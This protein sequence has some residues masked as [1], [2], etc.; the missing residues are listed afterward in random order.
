MSLKKFGIAARVRRAQ[1]PPLP[2]TTEGKKEVKSLLFLS[3]FGGG[4][5]HTHSTAETTKK[6]F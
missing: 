3:V 5:A 1:Q 2:R 6:F 4:R